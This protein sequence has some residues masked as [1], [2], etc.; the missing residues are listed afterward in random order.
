MPKASHFLAFYPEAA[1]IVNFPSRSPA[2]RVAAPR[3]SP[4]AVDHHTQAVGRNDDEHLILLDEGCCTPAHDNRLC[5]DV[6]GDD[7][8]SHEEA[9]Y[10]HEKPAAIQP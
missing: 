10:S 3:F 9:F 5:F 2:V 6:S 7:G 4:Q 1:Q 8:V